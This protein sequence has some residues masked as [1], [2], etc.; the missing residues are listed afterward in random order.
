MFKT[1]IVSLFTLLFLFTICTRQDTATLFTVQEIKGEA[2]LIRSGE[3]K[4]LEVGVV[5][6]EKDALVVAAESMVKIG[7]NDGSVMFVSSNTCINFNN[8]KKIKPFNAS[9]VVASGSVFL[10]KEKNDSLICE[11]YT[12]NGIATVTSGD[13]FITYDNVQSQLSVSAINDSVQVVINSESVLLPSCTHQAFKSNGPGQLEPIAESEILELKQWIPPSFIAIALGKSG[14][15][16]QA[17]VEQKMPPEW[18]NVPREIS[19]INVLFLDTAKAVDPE[20]GLIR[21][22][23]ANAPQGM[24]IDGKTGI[25][26]YIPKSAG[27]NSVRILA[28]DRDSMVSSMDYT[29]SVI[30][31]L[32]V[33]LCAP[34]I[35]RINQNV[36]ISANS[37]QTS[38]Q[39]GGYQYRFDCDGDGSFDIPSDGKFG[40]A[41]SV[42]YS[43]SKD[44]ECKIKVEMKDQNGAIFSATRVIGVKSSPKANLSISPSIGRTGAEFLLDATECTDKHEPTDSLLI[45]FDING[46]GKWDIPSASG[47][48]R[49]KKVVW[50]WPKA[51]KFNVVIEVVNKYGI[52]DT[53]QREVIVSNGLAIDSIIS[54]DTV[55]VGDSAQFECLITQHEFPIEKYEWNMDADT[56]FELLSIDKIARHVFKKEGMANVFCRV[57]DKKGQFDV[58]QKSIVIVN[59]H[60]EINAG[61]TYNVRINEKVMLKGSA[62]DNDSKIVSYGWDVDGDG[63]V[64]SVSKTNDSV[65]H[66]FL[67]SG[68]KVLSFVV[69]TDDGS[70]WKDSAIVNVTNKKPSAKAGDDIVSKSGKKI[71][72]TGTGKD[73]DMNISKY[74]WDFNGD[75]TF[76]WSS[77]QNGAISHNFDKYSQAV[78][79]VTDSDGEFSTDTIKVIICPNEM[80]TIQKD[81]FCIDT[82][83]SSSK[84]GGVPTVN[85]SYEDAQ[86]ACTDQGKHLCSTQEWQ[87]ACSGENN[88]YP[89]GKKYEKDQC[90]TIGNVYVKNKIAPSGE[91]A[92]C[93][94]TSGTFDMSGNVAEW[95]DAG[96]QGPYVYGG[97]WQN[98]KD[99]S[100]CDS[101][102]QL[103]N[104]RKYFYV[105]FRCCK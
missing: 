55:H 34:K 92:K 12:P 18:L 61:G 76:D 50:A 3:S 63:V 89:Y 42:N 52:S 6:R 25:I 93:A 41:S 23:L 29:L 65:A 4:L 14:C 33:Q 99:K 101:K 82:Y 28:I 30:N 44:V 17:P 69:T 36:S 49:E 94:G 100:K 73:E 74:E 62:Q 103:Q 60:A 24:V 79:K 1:K 7:L 10:S 32:G 57:T 83:E 86:K 75:G 72:L 70:K 77:T 2:T 38:K 35:A 48:L 13:V 8:N 53:F 64:D 59:N 80:K 16:A 51:G 21:F 46:D 71:K 104:G 105:G 88:A 85:I 47:F 68:R 22:V 45:R 90:N 67:R 56:S 40:S 43:Y 91:F 31:G 26:R 66:T 87:A 11:I 97:S 58:Q 54:R 39:K 5:L 78:F 19:A 9:A 96:K 95:V 81:K 102:V 84:K 27:T 98:G 20:G 15:S 37:L